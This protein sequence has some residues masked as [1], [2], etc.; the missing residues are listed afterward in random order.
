MNI[1]NALNKIKGVTLVELVIAIAIAGIGIVTLLN[2]F[3]SIAS[4]SSDP[5]ITQQSIAI[6]ESFIEEITTLPFLDP[7]SLSVCPAAPVSRSDF[8]NVCDY[9]GYSASTI[10]DLTGNALALSSYQ[11][12]VAVSNGASLAGHLGA[13]SGNDLLQIVVTITNPLGENVMLSAYRARY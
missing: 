12:S 13:I 6:A 3:S 7:S 9:N 8:D 11:V 1:V 5:M 4:R 10:T 2:N